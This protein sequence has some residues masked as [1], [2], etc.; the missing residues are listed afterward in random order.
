M[1]TMH[2]SICNVVSPHLLEAL[3]ASDDADTRILASRTLEHSSHIRDR[4]RRFLE[5]ADTT[6]AI[7]HQD[8][9]PTPQ[10]I[11]PDQ[12]LKQ[13]VHSSEA[14]SSAKDLAQKTL[15][16]KQQAQDG[17]D[18]RLVTPGEQP[19]QPLHRREVYDMK[20]LE[21]RIGKKDETYRLLPGK[22]VRSEGQAPVDDEIA[23]QAY[24]GCS[25][26]LDFYRQVLDY[27]FLNGKAIISSVH[28]VKGYQNAS[29][30]GDKVQQM[31]YG[32]GGGDLYN[33]TACLDIIGH[34]MTVSV[35]IASSLS[36]GQPSPLLTNGTQHAVI[37]HT[38]GLRYEGEPGA[39]NEH[40]AD[41]FG[42]LVTLWSEQKT[43]A[44]SDWLIGEGCLM[45]GVKGVALRN[46]KF[47][48]TAYDDP[49]V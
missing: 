13:V 43:S 27:R 36:F 8:E 1:H 29:W 23:N 18:P 10:G 45:P 30:M 26:V 24:E 25:K 47:P 38:C 9:E 37:E 34:E 40:L 48:G 12:L 28:F 2:P 16:I 4:R 7:S 31:V 33:F 49:K 11:V 5:E 46:M 21:Q 20:N 6:R 41:V 32:D 39:L 14:D 42:M 44:Q 35:F 3:A 17:P 15:D 22:L 19:S